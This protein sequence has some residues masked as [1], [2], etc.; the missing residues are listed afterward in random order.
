MCVTHP[1]IH[2]ILC[3]CTTISY[4]YIRCIRDEKH[5]CFQA[6]DHDT[7][8]CY[9][10]RIGVCVPVLQAIIYDRIQTKAKHK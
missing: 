8:V 2:K 1:Q 7:F 9:I 10:A 4:V 6:L 3:C 5:F